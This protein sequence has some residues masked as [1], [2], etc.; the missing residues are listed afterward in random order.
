MRALPPLFLI[1]AISQLGATDCGEV[2]RDSGFDLWCGDELC[3]WKVT[4]GAVRRVPT[5]NH[6]DPGV[7]LVGTDVAI[8]Q[9]SPV[10]YTD[11]RCIQFSLI[12]NVSD[13]A[14]VHLDVDVEGDGVVE[15]HERIPTSSWK[16]LSY[17]LAI[18]PPYDG[19]RFELTKRGNGT[20]VLAN[21][22]ARIVPAEDCAG[23][24]VL[25]PGPRRD[26]AACLP[27]REGVHGAQDCASGLCISSPTHLPA[28][29]WFSLA[30]AGC[31][32]GTSCGGGE[33][34]GLGDPF[35]PVFAIPVQC[36][37]LARKELGE[38]CLTDAECGNSICYRDETS[39][40]G[41]C[42]ACRS[43]VDCPGGQGC[44]PAWSGGALVCGA[45]AG[46]AA[47]GAPCGS[48]G[49][50]ASGVCSGQLRAECDDGRPCGSPAAC[51]FGI[52]GAAPLQNGACV[53]V[54]VQGGTCQ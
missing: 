1:A 15:L 31:T 7:E 53:T 37:P 41:V 28:S 17:N 24:T 29:G 47:S 27:E 40:V 20:A 54:G 9:L 39:S 48:D 50:C 13:T 16:P 46:V 19:I 6:G 52:G 3:A 26:G 21:I 14:E 43:A 11:G 44:G 25:D 8:Q 45:G 22:G 12:A 4:R 38:R 49:D 30:C 33:V 23:L 10:N 42:S 18:A 35:S 51:P 32:P 5:W 2:L 36:V 34:C